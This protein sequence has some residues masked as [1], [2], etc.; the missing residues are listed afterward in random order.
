MTGCTTKRQLNNRL[1]NSRLHDNRLHCDRLQD[2]L[3]YDYTTMHQN[4]LNNIYSSYTTTGCTTSG[5]TITHF[6]TV[7]SDA[8]C[9]NVADVVQPV[10]V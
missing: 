5:N 7:C 2:R 3:H 8:A 4:S 6:T 1:H 10:V 9:C